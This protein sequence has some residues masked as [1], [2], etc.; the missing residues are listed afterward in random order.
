VTN[1]ARK[2]TIN[3][4]ALNRVASV[5]ANGVTLESRAA[6]DG[7]TLDVFLVRRVTDRAATITLICRDDKDEILG[8]VDVV[9][10]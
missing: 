4:V 7:K 5:T 8:S 2:V 6:S 10:Q 3:G 9:I 1:D